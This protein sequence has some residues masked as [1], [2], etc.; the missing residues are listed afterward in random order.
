MACQLRSPSTGRP[1]ACRSVCVTQRQ[2]KLEI[3]GIVAALT[4][5]RV[6][7]ASTWFAVFI[8]FA[9]FQD[10]QRSFPQFPRPAEWLSGH[11]HRI[12]FD[13]SSFRD[14]MVGGHRHDSEIFSPVLIGYIEGGLLLSEILNLIYTLHQRNSVNS[15][16][17]C[18][19]G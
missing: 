12:R 1:L 2:M 6:V 7:G 8:F 10:W 3:A 5:G 16:Y 13:R 19:E 18:D 15:P 17:Y 14:L 4:A 11:F 9:S